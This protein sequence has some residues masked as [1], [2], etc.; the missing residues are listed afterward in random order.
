MFGQLG[1]ALDACVAKVADLVGVELVPAI[2]VELQ[3]ELR[4]EL[5]A[6]EVDEGIAHITVVLDRDMCTL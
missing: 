1:S 5:A 4:Y 6:K 3:V 2:V